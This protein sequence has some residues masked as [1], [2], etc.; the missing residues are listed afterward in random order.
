[1]EWLI[2]GVGV[3][4][5][6][7][8]FTLW[9]KS[10][11]ADDGRIFINRPPTREAIVASLAPYPRLADLL[12]RVEESDAVDELTALRAAVIK[13]RHGV[14]PST[15]A[16][17]AVNRLEAI[18]HTKREALQ[19][20]ERAKAAAAPEELAALRREAN[21]LA[22]K[23]GWKYYPIVGPSVKRVVATIEEKRG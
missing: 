23:H 20:G 8:A 13:E 11:R 10:W 4:I 19:L 22:E 14:D 12:R 21:D 16:G 15:P 18:V 3:L 17:R 6:A 9:R 5:L 1:M 7:T 2:V